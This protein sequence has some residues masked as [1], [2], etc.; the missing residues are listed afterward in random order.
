MREGDVMET[1]ATFA[2]D[3]LTI[4]AGSLAATITVREI[5]RNWNNLS[6][7]PERRARL[8]LG[9][10][11]ERI[12]AFHAALE[13][14][15]SKGGAINV[16]DEIA[17]YAERA[18]SLTRRAWA[19]DSRCASWFVTGPAKFPVAR[20]EKRMRSADTA[21]SAI[22]DHN[23]KALEA[24]RRRAWPHG[25]PGDA[26]RSNNPDAPNLIRNKIEEL[27]NS[28]SLSKLI[29]ALIRKHIGKGKDDA[30]AIIASETG[31]GLPAA[32]QLVTPDCL[33]AL[34]IPQ[35]RL[36]GNL[37][38]IKRLEGRLKSIE[39]IRERGTV[40]KEIE[41][42]AGKISIVENG[43]AARIQLVFSG[44]P[45]TATRGILKSNGFRWAP[46]EGAWQRHL[47]NA[48]R[49][50]AERVLKELAA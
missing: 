45:D 28:H 9:A 31:I 2:S 41:T 17:R 20:N 46:S 50:A 30:A 44:K 25:A 36:S 3:T 32:L 13:S 26:I 48:G 14:I 4:S 1:T 16:P 38:E 18:V 42:S 5:E 35:Y 40:E 22:R 10:L 23:A 24:V 34:G 6:Q 12:N 49:Y 11:A 43:E 8:E 33:G 27:R 21:Y 47:N 29:N 19:M 15:A 7:L 39:I 37:V